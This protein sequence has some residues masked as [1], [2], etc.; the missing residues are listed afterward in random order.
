MA[1]NEVPD[2]TPFENAVKPLY[3]KFVD[4]IGRDVLQKVIGARDAAKR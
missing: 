2:K 4:E 3:E 1:I